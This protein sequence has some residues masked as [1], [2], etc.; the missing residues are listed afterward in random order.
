MADLGS[1]RYGYDVAEYNLTDT[2]FTYLGD[3]ASI[4]S[5]S[6][7]T[8]VGTLYTIDELYYSAGNFYLSLD[9]SSSSTMTPTTS[10]W[11]WAERS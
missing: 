10:P 7:F 5:N 11:L 3:N 1:N 8:M 4:S 6:H 9:R 2:A